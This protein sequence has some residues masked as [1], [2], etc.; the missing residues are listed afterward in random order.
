M[1]VPYFSPW[2]TQQD[3]KSVLKSLN[4]RWFTNGP[5]LELFEKNFSNYIKCKYSLGVSSATS[6]LHLSLLALGIKKNDEV[7]VP[8][9]T[10]AA[11][12][13]A[14][15]FCGAK[16]VFCDVDYD[17]F[18][19]SVTDI[20]K[21]IT[22]KTKAIIIVHYGGQ[23]C[24]IYEIKKLCKEKNI[25]LIE[26]C[27][28]A[29]GSNYKNIKCGTFGIIGCF[30]FYPTK[31]ITTGEGGMLVTND[32]IIASK[33]KLLRSHGMNI[34]P[35]LREE[36]KLWAYDIMEMGYNY[37][38]DDIR[39]SLGLSQLKR[40]ELINKKRMDIAKK[41]FNK[42]SRIKG[43]T[44]PVQKRDRNHIFHLFT[45]KIENDYPLTRDELFQKLI[46]NGIGTSVQYIPLHHMTYQKSKNKFKKN[47]FPISD[48]LK[49]QIL[50]LPIF[51][52]MSL[53]QIDYVV[54][55]LVI[56]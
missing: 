23:S 19:I 44:L 36:K 27:A 40:V 14:V 15:T 24:D 1:K 33:I 28:H 9:M 45:I 17:T 48:K 31:I 26:D 38:L 29:L 51:P 20:K 12:A 30:S 4:Q 8:V 41:Y 52:T 11:T 13:D 6:A 43:I 42:L 53:K 34:I 56:K 39:A 49:N 7:I 21:K 46:S 37:R 18:N 3:K 35:R 54:N 32:K 50:S 2:I 16:V 55:Q 47:E 22:K 25:F 10:F 5:N